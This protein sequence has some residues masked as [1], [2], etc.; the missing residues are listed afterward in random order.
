[1]FL[2]CCCYARCIVILFIQV[3]ID[4]VCPSSSIA[5]LWGPLKTL[6]SIEI[7]F[8]IVS[9]ITIKFCN[10]LQVSLQEIGK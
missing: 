8:S 6:F 4:S 9:A 7:C 10:Y 3:E 1:M 5:V 2:K